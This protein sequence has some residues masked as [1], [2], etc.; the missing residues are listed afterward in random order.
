[1]S[2]HGLTPEHVTAFARTWF[3]PSNAVVQV[4]GPTEVELAYQTKLEP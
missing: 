3:V 1:M 2:E 4:T